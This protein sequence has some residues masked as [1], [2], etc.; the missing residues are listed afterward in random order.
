PEAVVLADEEDRMVA[1]LLD[2]L[3]PKTR[4]A[5]EQRF[6]LHDGRKRSYREIGEELGITAEGARRMVKRAVT[7]IR[8]GA[9][10]TQPA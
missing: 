1:A 7:T 5:V 3:D 4:L 2:V 8:D 9:R 6:G 10:T